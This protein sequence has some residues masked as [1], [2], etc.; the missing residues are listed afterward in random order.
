MRNIIVTGSGT[1]VGKTVVSA[2]LATALEADYWK[3]IQCG[4]HRHTD[5][6]TIKQL[7]PAV[8]VHQPTYT[9]KAP[10]SPHHAA[11]LEKKNPQSCF[12]YPS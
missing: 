7:V 1:G 12:N 3:P 10:R 2:I 6:E 8:T 5:S 9:L 11:R 4:D